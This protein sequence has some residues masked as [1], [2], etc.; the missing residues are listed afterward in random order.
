MAIIN[1]YW[2]YLNFFGGNFYWLYQKYSTKFFQ[3]WFER[4]LEFGKFPSQ[5]CDL[6]DLRKIG[7]VFLKHALRIID[8]WL[9]I[10]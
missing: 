10:K 8:N 2:I 1:L 6:E 9:L 5:F 7:L 4:A 3:E